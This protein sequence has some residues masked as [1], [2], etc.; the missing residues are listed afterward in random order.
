MPQALLWVLRG[1]TMRQR[2]PGRREDAATLQVERLTKAGMPCPLQ[3]VRA[4]QAGGRSTAWR[5]LGAGSDGRLD[6]ARVGSSLWPYLVQHVPTTLAPQPGNFPQSQTGHTMV[7][8]SSPSPSSSGSG[9]P[10]PQGLPGSQAPSRWLGAAIYP[11]TE[12][13]AG[14]GGTCGSRVGGDRQ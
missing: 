6:Q 11:M 8:L 10:G 12:P 4:L 7:H 9:A 3:S 2:P 1:D 14:V 5:G 13:E